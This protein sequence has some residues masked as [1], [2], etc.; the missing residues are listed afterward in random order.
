MSFWTNPALLIGRKKI[1]PPVFVSSA[2]ASQ[3]GSTTIAINKPAGVAIG[4]V[5]WAMIWTA[6]STSVSSLPTGWTVVASDFSGT[7]RYALCRKDV[8]GSEA[9]SFSFLFAGSGNKHGSILCYRGGLGLLNVAGAK[10]EATAAT[11]ATAASLAATKAGV[12]LG[13]FVLSASG[14]TVTLAPSG[15]TQRTLQSG[16]SMS[17]AGYDLTPSPAGSTP[18]KTLTWSGTGATVAG[19]QVQI[20]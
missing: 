12:L 7:H 17:S 20:Y 15:M 6:N 14:R 4:D 11:I 13:F 8:D 3:A 18:S 10:T 2:S 1:P 19:L 16:A 9:A 5:L